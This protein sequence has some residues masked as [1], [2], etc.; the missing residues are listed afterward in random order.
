MGLYW[1]VVIALAILGIAFGISS[2]F[3]YIVDKYL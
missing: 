1:A 2:M 3:V